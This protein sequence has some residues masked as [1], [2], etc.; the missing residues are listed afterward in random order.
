MRVFCHQFIKLIVSE[1]KSADCLARIKIFPAVIHNTCSHHPSHGG[2][3]HLCMDP[4]ILFIHQT[5]PDCIRKPA[6][7][8]LD[9]VAIFDQRSYIFR[10]CP[11]CIRNRN[12]PDDRKGPVYLVN[13]ISLVDG[14][15]GLSVNAGLPFIH[16]KND[17]IRAIHPFQG[18][19]KVKRNRATAILIHRRNG[20]HENSRSAHLQSGNTGRMQVHRHIAVSSRTV[21][22]TAVIIIEVRDDVNLP[23]Q[24]RI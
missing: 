12:L 10:N 4:Q 13:V 3:N 14:N 5:F 9:T 17:C 8:Q 19:F 1:S 18:S 11:V 15:T 6:E 7:S 22:F 23:F 24:R 20:T 21:I 16:L 2:R